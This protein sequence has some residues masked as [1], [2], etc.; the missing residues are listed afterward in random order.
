MSRR[1]AWCLVLPLL[2]ACSTGDADDARTHRDMRDGAAPDAPVDA[3]PEDAGR[4]RADASAP[5]GDGGPATADAGPGCAP[6][7]CVALGLACGPASDG[8]GGPLACGDCDGGAACVAGRCERADVDCS[9]IAARAGYEL[10]DSGPDF[11]AGVFTD[12]SGCRAFCAAAGLACRASHGGEPGCMGPEPSVLDC[13]ADSGHLSDWCECARGGDPPPPTECPT[14]AARPARRASMGYRAASYAP[15]SSWVLDC[16]DYAYTARFA[17]HEA[18]DAAY[19]AGSGRGTA[20]F[21]FTG[22]GPGRY[23]VFVAGRHTSNRNPAGMRVVVT[24]GGRSAV[25]TIDQRDDSG[26]TLED[27]HGR[28][29]LDGRVEVLVDSSVSAESD[30]VAS[31][32]LVP[33]P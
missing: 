10:C 13:D 28:H 3:G 17:E 12:G 4:E 27:L 30:S 1:D 33:A 15:R 20:S 32:T 2:I 16:R 5:P 6:T 26:E 25:A 8:C 31:V 23:D 14:D 29:C 7:T 18:C 11:C 19:R 24:S 22:V 9:G 21:V